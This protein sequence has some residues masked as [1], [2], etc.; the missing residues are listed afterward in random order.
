MI[1]FVYTINNILT[2]IEINS[3]IY[4]I[5]YIQH[6]LIT[7]KFCILSR[8]Y[9]C[10]YFN[11]LGSS[12]LYSFLHFFYYYRV[13]DIARNSARLGQIVR[14]E[15][16]YIKA[17]HIK[18]F[19]QII[20]SFQSFNMYQY[21]GTFIRQLEMF[22]FFYMSI[23]GSTCITAHPSCPFRKIFRCTKYGLSRLFAVYLWNFHAM[24]SQIERTK[25]ILITCIGG[26]N[27]RTH[28]M[29]LC[30]TDKILGRLKTDWSM[31]HIYNTKIKTCQS[32]LFN[33]TSRTS[34]RPKWT[35]P[36]ISHATS[37]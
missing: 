34:F 21:H 19:I 16:Y 7:P 14:A 9:K 10:T 28:S 37:R 5:G 31:L 33:R 29:K 8:L 3:A 1:L 27:Y 20:D 18:D 6:T 15:E 2:S 22:T 23:F 26:T 13:C 11:P 4:R 25:D 36:P 30:S 17:F 24:R 35:P 12:F 32:R